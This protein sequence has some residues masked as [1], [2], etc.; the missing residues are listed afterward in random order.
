MYKCINFIA[1]KLNVTKT[2]SSG[3]SNNKQCL[4]ESQTINNVST[5]DVC[6]TNVYETM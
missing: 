6:N 4:V 5:N 2:M 3:E 1:R